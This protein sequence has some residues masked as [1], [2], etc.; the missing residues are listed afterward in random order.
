MAKQDRTAEEFD[1]LM[2]NH[3][4][5]TGLVA[6]SGTRTK[7]KNAAVGGAPGSRHLT[8][9]ARDYVG[10]AEAMQR[11]ANWA[12]EQGL[13]YTVHNVGSGQHLHIQATPTRT[14]LK[15]NPKQAAKFEAVRAARRAEAPTPTPEPLTRE[16]PVTAEVAKAPKPSRGA[17][18]EY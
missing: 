8:G 7:E 18:G 3:F 14:W 4:D 16:E 11:G 5:S 2:D 6:T 9:Q 13:T 17:T 10:T 15:A 12:V 1:E